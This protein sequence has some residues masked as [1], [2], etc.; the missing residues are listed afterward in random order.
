MEIPARRFSGVLAAD[1]TLKSSLILNLKLQHSY[2]QHNNTVDRQYRRQDAEQLA[3]STEPNKS[4][5][6][7]V[8]NHCKY[9]DRV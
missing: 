8:T 9:F 1:R 6:Q 7:P 4:R 5:D 3:H 2:T